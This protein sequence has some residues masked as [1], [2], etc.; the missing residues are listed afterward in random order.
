MLQCCSHKSPSDLLHGL[1]L[2]STTVSDESCYGVQKILQWWTLLKVKLNTR[3]VKKKN[4]SLKF[5]DPGKQNNVFVLRML[6][7]IGCMMRSWFSGQHTLGF[8]LGI[9]S[10]GQPDHQ[11][12]AATNLVPVWD[13][14]I[15]G[16]LPGPLLSINSSARGGKRRPWSSKCS[17]KRLWRNLLSTF[18]CFHLPGSFA[19]KGRSRAGDAPLGA[20]RDHSRCS[21][22]R[23]FDWF[24]IDPKPKLWPLREVVHQTKRRLNHVWVLV[25]MSQSTLS[26]CFSNLSFQ[27]RSSPYGMPAVK[28]SLTIITFWWKCLLTSYLQAVFYTV[29]R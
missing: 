18:V 19:V 17:F 27:M 12:K 20:G 9:G 8:G 26:F 11:G 2:H 23:S 4:L 22:I 29:G 16:N 5:A 15:S 14:L 13:T 6:L 10:N 21:S 1:N 24:G 7:L 3:S 25:G 28:M